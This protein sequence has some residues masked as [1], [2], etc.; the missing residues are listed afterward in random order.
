VFAA[1]DCAALEG[2]REEKS[3]VV[4]VRH[5]TVLHRNL[6]AAVRDLPLAAYRPAAAALALVSCGTRYAIAARGSFVAEGRWAWYWKD[7]IDRR[8][9]ASLKA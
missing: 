5:G 2:A 4:A 3:G 8:W 7:W 1:G 6:A 9:I